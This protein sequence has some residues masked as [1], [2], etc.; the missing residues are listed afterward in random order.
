MTTTYWLSLSAVVGV[1]LTRIASA[2]Q[3]APLHVC[4]GVDRVLR[5]QTGMACGAG[6]SAYWLFDVGEDKSAPPTAADLADLKRKLASLTQEVS[7]LEGRVG[8]TVP[9]TIGAPFT[10]IDKNDNKLL[11]VRDDGSVVVTAP[12]DVN[13]QNGKGIFGVKLDPRGMRIM[14]AA[15]NPVAVATAM[16]DGGG[17]FK[18]FTVDL[19][20][21]G[22]ARRRSWNGARHGQRWVRLEPSDD[23]RDQG[24]LVN[25][26]RPEQD[27]HGGRL[28]RP[29]HKR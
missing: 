28:A 16:P 9:H 25:G 19:E 21:R 13:D 11:D 20:A 27:P 14:D 15:G 26:L 10:V 8:S 7:R 6:Q 2:Q 29:G 17:F 23:D 3:T 4:I 5:S 1:S 24:R 18:A 12:F 22:G